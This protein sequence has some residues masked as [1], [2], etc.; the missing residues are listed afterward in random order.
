MD[1]VMV[2]TPVIDNA[3]SDKEQR[4][5]RFKTPPEPLNAT[6]L[7][8]EPI[9]QF[10]DIIHRS[11]PEMDAF[12]PASVNVGTIKTPSV[13]NREWDFYGTNIAKRSGKTRI[14]SSQFFYCYFM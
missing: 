10:V 13:I 5:G 11:V 1:Y 9:A 4:H 12:C 3:S 14:Q 7:F 8:P 2:L 6:A